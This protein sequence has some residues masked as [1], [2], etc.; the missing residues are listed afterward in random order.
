MQQELRL[1]ESHVLCSVLKWCW[2]RL[3]GGVVSWPVYEA[4]K[5]GEFESHQARHAFETFIPIATASDA[6]NNIVVD[7]FDLMAAVA[8]HG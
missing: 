7:F 1:T 5:I 2:S 6:R 3:P 4:F 8:A